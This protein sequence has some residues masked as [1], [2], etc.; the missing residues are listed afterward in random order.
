MDREAASAFLNP[1]RRQFIPGVEWDTLN[2]EE[3]E[4]WIEWFGTAGGGAGK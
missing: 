2:A 4:E 1:V 3:K